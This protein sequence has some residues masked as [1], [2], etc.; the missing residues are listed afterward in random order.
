[1]KQD[2]AADSTRPKTGMRDHVGFLWRFVR[3]ALPFWSAEHK[4]MNRGRL[5]ADRGPDGCAG[6]GSGRPE[7]LVGAALQRDR[8]PPPRSVPGP[9]RDLRAPA[10]G[11]HPR[12]LHNALHQATPGICLACLDH[13]KHAVGLDGARKTLSARPGRGR[14]RR[15]SGRANRRRY[16]RD[17]RVGRRAGP[18]LVLLHPALWDIRRRAVGRSPVSSTWKSAGRSFP[19]LASWS[20]SPLPI[21]RSAPAWRYGRGSRWS[22]PPICGRRWKPIS[23]LAWRVPGNIRKASP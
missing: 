8:R 2:T 18:G 15:Q 6:C 5:A 7:F 1:M 10:S 11:E 3:F 22:A 17:D 4:W 16:S 12:V 14:A 9:D 19:S 20:S 21:R 23:G 13:Q